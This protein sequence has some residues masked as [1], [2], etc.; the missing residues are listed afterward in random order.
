MK[1]FAKYQ[2]RGNLQGRKNIAMLK[3]EGAVIVMDVFMGA[4]FI[5]Q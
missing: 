3:K 5:L 1:S 2:L 4:L